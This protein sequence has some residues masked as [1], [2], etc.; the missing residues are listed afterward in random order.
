MK[1]S[2]YTRQAYVDDERFYARMDLAKKTCIPAMIA[3][4]LRAQHPVRW[5][6]WA[7][8]R[9]HAHVRTVVRGYG[10]T[11]P[12]TVTSGDSWLAD[13]DIQTT[14]DSDD[15]V[16]AGFLQ[17]VQDLHEPGAPYLVSWQPVKLELATGQRYRM[18][19]RYSGS[20][21]SMFYSIYNPTSDV[22]VYALTHTRMSELCKS[23][24]APVEGSAFAVIHDGN[25]LM[26]IHREEREL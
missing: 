25:H 14:L 23:F 10:W 4:A 11:G 22:R 19:M 9:H 1:H 15:Q 8:P 2:V 13:D 12:L 20:T 17:N 26:Q 5:V 16:D 21:P 7:F 18:R 24:L 3:A 6:W